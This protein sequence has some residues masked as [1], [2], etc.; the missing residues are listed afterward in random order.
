MKTRLDETNHMRKLMGLPLLNEQLSDN[1]GT[2]KGTVIDKESGDPAIFTMVKIKDK[3]Y[4]GNTDMNG[5]YQI[6]KVPAGTYTLT[7]G[8][9]EYAPIE[10]EVTVRAG[11][12]TKQNLSVINVIYPPNEKDDVIELTGIEV[13]GGEYDLDDEKEKTRVEEINLKDEL[14]EL[15]YLAEKAKEKKE[16][17]KEKLK[18]F[19]K[20]V[21]NNK[22]LSKKIASKQKELDK[23]EADLDNYKGPEHFKKHKKQI[24]N[25]I[26]TVIGVG[27]IGAFNLFNGEDKVNDALDSVREKL[28]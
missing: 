19:L 13:V 22:K 21:K 6:S 3:S 23:L 25:K 1:T 14:E 15:E 2:I 17:D 10:I 11:K 18:S 20:D 27:I 26:L 16:S 9:M 12:T 24:I 4:G 5:F 28:G 8:S 7:I